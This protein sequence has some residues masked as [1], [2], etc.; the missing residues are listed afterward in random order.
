MHRH[1]G[2]V[3]MLDWYVPVPA[4]ACP[5][6]ESPVSE[7]QGSDADNVL[8]VWRQ[9]EAAPIGWRID[10]EI[11]VPG[12]RDA[13]RLPRHFSIFAWDEA[14]HEIVAKGDAPGG[15]WASTQI[16]LPTVAD[17]QG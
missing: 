6:C 15:I 2:S 7:W 10:E 1:D 11:E 9:G 4:L 12:A 14:G 13:A 3:G 16:D 8:Y 17:A 5:V